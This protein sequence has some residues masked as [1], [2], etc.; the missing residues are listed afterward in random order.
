MSDVTVVHVEADNKD[1]A[2]LISGLDQY[3]EPLYPPEE[4]FTVDFAAPYIQD[5]YFVVAYVDGLPAGC[6]AIRPL[7]D[8]EVELKRFYVEPS[9]RRNGVAARLLH[10]LEDKARAN[11]SAA[12][13]LETGVRQP[14]SISFYKKM[15]FD[16]IPLFGEYAD[17]P[18]SLCFGKL[19]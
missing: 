10:F 2:W 5:T 16:E 9:F 11:G 6:G 13:K 18:T 17:C 7:N 3:L 19:L 8:A 1:L 12:I 15:G 4:I 14:E